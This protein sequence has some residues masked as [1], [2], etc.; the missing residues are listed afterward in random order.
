MKSDRLKRVKM[1]SKGVGYTNIQVKQQNIIYNVNPYLYYK[2]VSN[3]VYLS[4]YYT[5]MAKVLYRFQSKFD[6]DIPTLI[7]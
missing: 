5:F 1:K 7:L 3:S 6:M 2:F 4:V